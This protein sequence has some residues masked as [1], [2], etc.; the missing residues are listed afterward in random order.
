MGLLFTYRS[1][2][3]ITSSRMQHHYEPGHNL[4]QILE[5]IEDPAE[6]AAII[7]EAY[8]MLGELAIEPV[9]VEESEDG[10]E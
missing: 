3:I 5:T 7:D 1:A 2:W 4:E 10:D 6:R 8:V 9:V